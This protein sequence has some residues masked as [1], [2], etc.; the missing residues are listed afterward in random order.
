MKTKPRVLF[1]FSV[2]LVIQT[3]CLIRAQSSN[4]PPEVSV[5]W[6][7]DYCSSAYF[8]EHGM[9]F[10]IKA[11]AYDPDGSI[12]QV[13]FFSDN[14]LIGVVSN[15]PFSMIWTASPASTSHFLKCVAFD[16]LGASRESPE[17]FVQYVG[18]FPSPDIFEITSPING[19]VFAAPA[20]FDF[21]AEILASG[22]C[23]TGPVQFFA[24]TNLLG[25]VTQAGP[26]T[27]STALY[28]LT[29]TNL[30]EGDY[31]LYLKKSTVTASFASG[32]CDR[33]YVHVTKLG[34][35]LPRLTPDSRFEFD[36]VTSFPTNQNVIEVS[37]NLLNWLPVS[38]NVPSRNSFTFT[39]PSLATNSPRFYRAVVPSQ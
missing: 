8:F 4:L 36:V 2:L 35:Q 38:T 21:S 34:M 12:A 5:L 7:A 39:E 13:Q 3:K 20:K 11:T 29:V 10:K 17:I 25:I 27:A 32:S 33:V 28:S 37:S 6:P 9:C 22:D 14:N 24:G 18:G 26:F 16:N 1:L 15:A 31:Q 30:P 23:G 19:S